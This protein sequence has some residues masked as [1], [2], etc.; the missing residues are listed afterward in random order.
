MDSESI[1]YKIYKEILE[2]EEISMENFF[3]HH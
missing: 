2:E 1:A 3:K